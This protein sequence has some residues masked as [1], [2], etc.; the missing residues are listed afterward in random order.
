MAAAAL[1]A[2]AVAGAAAAAAAAQV[3]TAAAAADSRM[4]LLDMGPIATLCSNCTSNSKQKTAAMAADVSMAGLKRQPL[5]GA[6]AADKGCNLGH[7]TQAH[8]L[9]AV[10]GLLLLQ[11][12]AQ[13]EQGSAHELA[14]S[15]LLSLALI[16]AA[17]QLVADQGEIQQ[18]VQVCLAC[19]IYLC[20]HFL[21]IQ[22]TNV[23]HIA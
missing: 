16:P 21:A 3:A 5:H 15:M 8:M 11:V 4:S 17:Q 14:F 12:L 9:C 22:H 18:L 7:P 20:C 19:L 2:A 23:V 13:V 1:V 6:S 10:P